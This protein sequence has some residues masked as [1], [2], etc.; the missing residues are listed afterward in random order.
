MIGGQNKL[1]A[2]G[3]SFVFGSEL[4]DCPDEFSHSNKTWPALVAKDKNLEYRC[5]ARGGVSNDWIVRNVISNVDQI[6]K[7][8]MVIVQW[9]FLARQ[10]FPI[11]NYTDLGACMKDRRHGIDPP[12]W[13]S[14]DNTNFFQTSAHVTSKGIGL[15]EAWARNKNKNVLESGAVEFNEHFYRKSYNTEYGLYVALKNIILCQSI[16]K[17][18]NY[19][20]SFNSDDILSSY[21]SITAIQSLQDRILWQNVIRFGDR[22]DELGIDGWCRHRNFARGPYNH[23]LEEAHQEA[24]KY[25][26]EMKYV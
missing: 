2:F 6:D 4:K 18:K 17:G 8:D 25:V 19:R 11:E 13:K 5:I 22:K 23:P 14:F 3:D 24:F 1:W 20:F 15:D 9:T 10:E 12:Y 21:K 26:K 16:L 7:N